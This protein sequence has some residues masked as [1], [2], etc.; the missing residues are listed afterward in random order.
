ML[1]STRRG[2]RRAM[3]PLG[4]VLTAALCASTSGCLAVFGGLQNTTINVQY[5][6]N[7]TGVFSGWTEITVGGDINSVN[8]ATLVSVTLDASTPV[9]TPDLSFIGSL[10]GEAV[11]ATARTTVVTLDSFPKG[12]QSVA[13]N[14]VYDGDLHPLFKDSQTIRIEWTGTSN[15]AFTAWPPGGVGFGVQ[16]NVQ[17]DVE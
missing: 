16:G 10:K 12:E 11:T 4:V 5:V 1:E 8:S 2:L 7:S 15:P 14:V 3:F 9:G 13:M 6:P 17:I